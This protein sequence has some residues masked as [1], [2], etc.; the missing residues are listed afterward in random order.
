MRPGKPLMHGRDGERSY[1]GLPG[2]PVSSLVCARI[3]GQPLVAR[4]GG[5]PFR[6]RWVAATLGRDLPANDHREE[7]MRAMV[8][9]GTP[10]VVTPVLHQDSSLTSRY[11]Q[12]DALVRRPANAPPSKVGDPCMALFVR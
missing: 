9:H 2:N 8:T 5:R 11:A 4:L 1:L 10:P 3:F 6:H 7:Y 12:A